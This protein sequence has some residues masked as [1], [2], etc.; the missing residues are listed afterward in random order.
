MTPRACQFRLLASLLLCGAGSAM[1]VE[2]QEPPTATD[3]VMEDARETVRSTAEWL[4]SGLDSWFGDIPFEDGGKVLDGRL[5][6]SIYQRQHESTDVKLRFNARFRLPNLEQKTYFFV[7]RDNPREVVSDQPGIFSRQQRLRRE[8][9]DDRS[10]F[11]GLGR[12]L[13]D[14]VDFRI[15]FR[16]GLKPYLQARY[17]QPWALGPQDN[18]EFRQTFFWSVADHLGST[19]AASYE[20]AYTPTLTARWVSA[21]TITQADRKFNWYSSLGAFKD[22]GRERLFSVEL[23][24][25]GR[26]S[27]GIAL[28][29]YG[30]QAR[31]EQ[32][33][34]K[35]WL[36]GE[37]ILGHFWPRDDA[38]SPRL[39]SWAVG[40]GLKMR[41]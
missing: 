16:G 41:F 31:W 19:T 34:Y 26:Q 36:A 13:N 27:T 15:G 35:N 17:R 1:A 6:L 25:A 11:A 3:A 24:A 5:S 33:V 37:I 38:A 4:A 40:T 12:V 21:A 18:V 2:G 29:D 14:R 7:G 10:F 39:R 8:T 30:V 20:H 23:L 9:A 22:F 32:P 28:S